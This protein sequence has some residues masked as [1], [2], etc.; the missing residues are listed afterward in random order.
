MSQQKPTI[1]PIRSSDP[2]DRENKPRELV[3]TLVD[4][5]IGEIDIGWSQGKVDQVF[6]GPIEEKLV[7]V[8]P[9]VDQSRG[10]RTVND[11]SGT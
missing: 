11:S 3:E 9:T 1:Q 7:R 8:F 4:Q 6:S 5:E 2:I 10:R